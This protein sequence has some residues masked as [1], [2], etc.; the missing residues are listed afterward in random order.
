MY[1]E[2]SQGISQQFHHTLHDRKSKAQTLGRGVFLVECIEEGFLTFQRESARFRIEN[3][4]RSERITL[5]SLQKGTRI[6]SKFLPAGHQWV[7]PEAGVR[8]QVVDLK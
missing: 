1:R 7:E 8:F 3:A 2:D 5:W 4:Y 6:K